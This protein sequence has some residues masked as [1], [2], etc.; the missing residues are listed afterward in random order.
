MNHLDVSKETAICPV[1]ATRSGDYSVPANGF[2]IYKCHH[3]G[4]EH[5]F[6]IP[7]LAELEAFYNGYTD[8]RAN[9]DVV[10]LN[11]RSNLK[12]LEEFGYVAGHTILDFGTG[13]GDFVA[14]AGENCYGIDFKHSDVPRVYGDLSQLPVERFDFITL[15]GVLEHLDD[16]VGILEQLHSRLSPGGK[17]V[18]TTVDAE[19]TIPYYYKPVE[20]LTY[21]TRKAFDLLFEKVGM[22]LVDHR[23]YTMMQLSAIY[24]DRLLSRTPAQYRTALMHGLT[25]M[26]DYVEVPTNE[27]FMVAQS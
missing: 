19:G 17:I 11:A 24:V 20:H 14:I 10:R 7:T 27:V 25:L 26:P 4:L 6:P 16:P 1:C 9:Q 13:D 22:R 23:P 12:R 18:L 2:R 8:I 3:C 5:T 15:W 21:W